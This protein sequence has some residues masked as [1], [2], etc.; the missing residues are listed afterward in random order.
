MNNIVYEVC[1]YNI[2]Y[3]TYTT[4]HKTSDYMKACEL[5]HILAANLEYLV[6]WRSAG[7]DM[8]YDNPIDWIEIWKGWPE[9]LYGPRGDE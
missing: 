9:I 3:D 6:N 7:F 8:K 1:G 4:Y 5:A 2:E